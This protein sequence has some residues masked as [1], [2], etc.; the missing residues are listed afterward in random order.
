MVAP[1]PPLAPPGVGRLGPMSDVTAGLR[2]RALAAVL[3]EGG[4]SPDDLAAVLVAPIVV[5]TTSVVIETA[6]GSCRFPV[7]RLDASWPDTSWPDTAWI[8]DGRFETAWFDTAWFD[9]AWPDTAWFDG[10]WLDDGR[11]GTNKPARVAATAEK[12]FVEARSSVAGYPCPLSE[13]FALPVSDP[14]GVACATAALL[15]VIDVMR[16]PPTGW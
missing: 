11:T 9:T 1:A 7:C 15:T 5:A 2:P 10:G 6:F 12:S 13:L 3:L 8:D 14:G 16:F 4:V